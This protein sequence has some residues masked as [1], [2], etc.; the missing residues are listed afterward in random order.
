VIRRRWLPLA[1][2]VVLLALLAWGVTVVLERLTRA[3]PPAAAAGTA[4]PPAETPHISATLFYAAPD[5]DALVAVRREVPL[6]QGI[7]AQGRQILASQLTAPPDSY[8]S[9]IPAGTMLRAFYVT[10]RGDAFVDLSR[11]VT[12]AH[13]GGSLTELLTVQAIV[14][15]VVANLPAVQRV[16]IMVE[17]KEVDTIAGHIDVRRPLTRDTA[18]IREPSS[19]GEAG[20]Q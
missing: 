15:A 17:G 9:A 8:V 18:L 3:D 6:A 20:V 1:V 2:G 16:Q 14:S 5:G 19:E 11:E 12:T 13:P 7:E 10:E 4:D